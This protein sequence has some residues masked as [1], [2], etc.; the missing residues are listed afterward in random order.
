MN[1]SYDTPSY[2]KRIR[3]KYQ[4]YSDAKIDVIYIN[5]TEDHMKKVDEAV[6]IAQDKLKFER[7]PR[8]SFNLRDYWKKLSAWM[9][10]VSEKQ[11]KLRVQVVKKFLVDG[12]INEAGNLN[13]E[14]IDIFVNNLKDD[15]RDN[16]Q[17]QIQGLNVFMGF[18]QLIPDKKTIIPPVSSFQDVVFE[19]TKNYFIDQSTTILKGLV[20]KIPG[21]KAVIGLAEF[22]Q[23]IKSDYDNRKKNREDKIKEA[24]DKKNQ[25]DLATFLSEAST[26]IE[27]MRDGILNEVEKIKEQLKNEFT[28]AQYK[29]SK[30]TIIEYEIMSALIKW[31]QVVQL[32]KK[33][34]KYYTSLYCANWITNSFNPV[35]ERE[36]GDMKILF[37][38]I[39]R[40][41]TQ[42]G[43][44][45][46]EVRAA[47]PARIAETI[48]KNLGVN[49][50]VRMESIF[51][52]P[53]PKTLIFFFQPSGRGSQIKPSEKDL[54]R[55]NQR[56]IVVGYENMMIKI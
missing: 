10:R 40:P 27:K 17:N 55:L 7:P 52:L 23:D 39:A 1:I 15:L 54:V 33:S 11:R 8:F 53:V 18:M 45:S 34:T 50:V 19:H 25:K 31:K 22:Y 47:F 44:I 51:D 28:S 42:V 41:S 6:K 37:S 20:E 46:V 38:L 24:R 21:G 4:N 48:V 56:N 30:K 49:G 14:K 43:D 12:T 3:K 36:S 35:N 2:E 29:G 13:V 32:Y 5:L 16:F 26:E 9:K